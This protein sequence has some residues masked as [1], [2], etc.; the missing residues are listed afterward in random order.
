MNRISGKTSLCD[1][2]PAFARFKHFTSSFETL[3][4]FEYAIIWGR[5][6]FSD[7]INWCSVCSLFLSLINLSDLG[8]DIGSG[9]IYIVISID[10]VCIG[11]S[12]C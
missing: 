4:Y 5:V 11:I 7:E 9:C 1:L 6:G 8:D 10:L 2:N 12:H 3:Y